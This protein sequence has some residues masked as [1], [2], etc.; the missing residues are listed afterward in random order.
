MSMKRTRTQTSSIQRKLKLII[1]CLMSC[2][3][4]FSQNVIPPQGNA[5]K[6][7]YALDAPR[8]IPDNNSFVI[9]TQD[10]PPD[11]IK[12]VIISSA[13]A[14][15]VGTP[16]FDLI[17]LVRNFFLHKDSSKIELKDTG[18][19]IG[20]KYSLVDAALVD[21][22]IS[23]DD[24]FAQSADSVASS[25]LGQFLGAAAIFDPGSQSDFYVAKLNYD[26]TQQTLI[27]YDF[28]K[29]GTDG[30]RLDDIT[31][32]SDL[33]IVYIPK[34]VIDDLSNTDTDGSISIQAQLLLGCNLDD[35]Q[36][37]TQQVHVQLNSRRSD[38][39]VVAPQLSIE[40]NVFDPTFIIP[41]TTPDCAAQISLQDI[42]VTL[43][44]FD[45]PLDLGHSE[46][47]QWD[48]NSGH[49][50]LQ[51]S[52]ISTN[53][54]NITIKS[55][56]IIASL[57]STFAPSKPAIALDADS[58]VSYPYGSFKYLDYDKVQ[59][60]IDSHAW[61]K[62]HGNTMY[63]IYTH[64]SKYGPESWV[65]NSEWGKVVDDTVQYLYG[66][67]YGV[68]P[69]KSN[70]V[71]GGT[72]TEL[73]E[74]G[75]VD[76][77][78]D[79]ST[80]LYDLFKQPGSL[81]QVD[82]NNAGQLTPLSN[83]DR[84]KYFSAIEQV[85]TLP[86]DA[87]TLINAADAHVENIDGAN[88][89]IIGGLD[90][91]GLC[92]PDGSTNNM[93]IPALCAHI[94]ADIARHF[95]SVDGQNG[96]NENDSMIGGDIYLRPLAV[97]DTY[98]VIGF[99]SPK[100]NG[101]S[102]AAVMKFRID[103]NTQIRI[104]KS[105][106][107]ATV[108]DNNNQYS[109]ADAQYEIR[110]VS[111]DA[112]IT[113]VTT[114]EDGYS[115][116]FTAK[117]GEKYYAKEIHAPLGFANSK[118]PVNFETGIHDSTLT[119]EVGD[120][121]QH[122]PL[123]IALKKYDKD[124]HLATPQGDAQLSGGEFLVQFYTG[125]YTN[126]EE[127]PSSPTR[128]WTLKSDDEGLVYL[129]ENHKVSGDDFYKDT[130]G[131]ITLPLGTILI[132][133]LK[134][135]AG[136]KLNNEYSKLIN[137][138]AN[139]KSEKL[140]VY[141][142]PIIEDEVRQSHL[143]I[144]KLDTETK[145]NEPLGGASLEAAQ[146][147]IINMS[148]HAISFED[149][150]VESGEIVAT[151]TTDEKGKASI[152]LP[153]GTYKIQEVVAPRGYL[154]ASPSSRTITLH[155]DSDAVVTFTT[156]FEEQVIR[157]DFEFSKNDEATNTPLAHIPFRLTSKTTGESHLLVSDEN[158]MVNTAADWN[159]HTS[160]TNENDAYISEDGLID[161][162]KLNP[163]A[164]VW[165]SGKQ[166]LQG[167]IQ[168]TL[169]ALPYDTYLL[170]ELR[171][172]KNKSHKLISR[173]VVINRH[174]RTI[175]I[176]T[177][178]DRPVVISTT[179]TEDG[180]GKKG[181]DEHEDIHIT[182]EVHY[183]NLTPHV[184]Y[185]LKGELFNRVTNQPV[186]TNTNEPVKSEVRFTPTEASGVVQ[187]PFSFSLDPAIH[188]DIVAYEAL[189]EEEKLLL[190]HANEFDNKQTIIVYATPTLAS[191]FVDASAHENND[192]YSYN[193][194]DY[195]SYTNLHPG[196]SYTLTGTIV[197]ASTGKTILDD[198]GNAL[199]VTKE[200]K[201]STPDGL[202]EVP[203]SFVSSDLDGMSLVA[204]QKLSK[205]GKIVA[206]HEDLTNVDQT[207]HMPLIT[208]RF[209][210]IDGE[211]ELSSSNAQHLTD[212][213]SFKNLVPNEQYRLVTMI[214]DKNTS[215]LLVQPDGESLRIETEFT[216]QNSDG[217][218]QVNLQLGAE[219]LFGRTLVAYEYLYKG[220][221][222]VAVH[223]DLQ[224]LEQ[225]ITSPCIYTKFMD[226][227][228][229]KDV[230]A[231]DHTKL[232]DRIACC[233]LVPDTDYVIRTKLF[234]RTTKELLKDNE[235]HELVWEKKVHATKQNETFDVELDI[236]TTAVANC[237]LVAFEYLIR[238]DI[239]RAKHEDIQSSEQTITIKPPEEKLP[240][241]SDGSI[242]FALQG[243]MCAASLALIVAS[244][245]RFHGL[246]A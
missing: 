8:Y 148:K 207:I 161:E 176:G 139:S 171:V 98:I 47:A 232:I 210:N 107:N 155:P 132:Q 170:E 44:G 140:D 18:H 192:A 206:Q 135:P 30:K 220:D 64:A 215:N 86:G 103:Y 72:Y 58:M 78:L 129:D 201:P 188:S 122:N 115:P 70:T 186:Q 100:T 3:L 37:T 117:K 243:L 213:V 120:K 146:F 158:G 13:D 54:L 156:K 141:V 36:G 22:D 153:F 217:T 2:L 218:V 25:F 208:S 81:E 131:S 157:G 89:L 169:G 214:A 109:L 183:E 56:G 142:A 152:D 16:N 181:I 227:E 124:F 32:D 149:H 234:N 23:I 53:R 137:I 17:R 45:T 230:V 93:V 66:S 7:A 102:G 51:L 166:N 231:Q 62:Y 237:E 147:H 177:L 34:T 104:H 172:S 233:N 191:R 185:T 41:V 119:V 164:G 194:I 111:D 80:T 127:L 168:D 174:N 159:K 4:T 222:L 49:L 87:G 138:T 83:Y 225:T 203:F 162:E 180:S 75:F 136:Y 178:D 228:G 235:G 91:T 59:E 121:P 27:N 163:H 19:A 182:D 40:S 175:D 88:H 43:D 94:S 26:T 226:V 29:Q 77:L 79:S 125:V 21:K 113:T 101:Q 10:A 241:T 199:S 6:L 238:D 90:W 48:A 112:L 160:N 55:Q 61:W 200:F 209:Q 68:S 154:F 14:D 151:L 133:E 134:A 144:Q 165:F 245:I 52:S 31:L 197:D 92:A 205:D 35:Q 202:I 67:R 193:M 11:D 221:A 224:D 60:A 108:S 173:E 69:T 73:N 76:N 211:Q 242:A 85:F 145:N 82:P 187:V 12:S 179:L 110:R 9:A 71:R 28:A 15:L 39:P 20:V 116:Y 118:D 204:F 216:P 38:I 63:Y 84:T 126:T 219:D 198:E 184:E 96:M 105:S 106:Q 65:T 229:N 189:F 246:P 244:R 50:V 99:I 239:E 240:N 196:E 190:E 143:Q 46:F 123:I 130:E 150:T 95:S 1:C 195:V 5:P 24:Y 57:L 236:D 128:S 223:A 42:E 33:G 114:N 212:I 74:Q 167:S 97:T